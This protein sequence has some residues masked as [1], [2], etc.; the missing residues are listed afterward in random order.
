MAEGKR[1]SSCTE[2]KESSEF[3]RS[4]RETDGLQWSCK[5]CQ[6]EYVA[7][8]AA[9]LV[10]PCEVAGCVGC[11]LGSGGVL[12]PQSSFTACRYHSRG[13][14]RSLCGC[15]GCAAKRSS[16]GKSYD[17][18]HVIARDVG[19]AWEECFFYL[20]D[21]EVGG[22]RWYTYGISRHVLDRVAVYEAAADR[23]TLIDVCGV[24]R[25]LANCA[26]AYLQS[27]FLGLKYS[28]GARISGTVSESLVW[29]RE[30]VA[31]WLDAAAWAEVGAGPDG[32]D[33]AL[34]RLCNILV[35]SVELGAESGTLDVWIV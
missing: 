30:S 15:K 22:E 14:V 16:V 3:H 34:D 35:S 29:S 9:V 11:S 5:V 6:C 17:L 1:C 26:E 8:R 23:V 21:I 18:P 19:K 28:P 31:A 24:P 20:V 27:Y 10:G 12:V 32:V 7:A 33:V 13:G 2:V 4:G 25:L